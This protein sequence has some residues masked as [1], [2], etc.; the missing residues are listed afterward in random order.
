[1]KIRLIL[2]ALAL[3][4]CGDN[5]STP[6][7]TTPRTVNACSTPGFATCVDHDSKSA[8]ECYVTDT[9]NGEHFECVAVCP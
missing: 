7:D 5:T 1:M 6:C 3:S 9:G 2:L 4:A 8:T